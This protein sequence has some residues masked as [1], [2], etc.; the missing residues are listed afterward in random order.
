MAE[1]ICGVTGAQECEGGLSFPRSIQFESLERLTGCPQLKEGRVGR[2][3]SRK[4]GVSAHPT[5]RIRNEF[6]H[7]LGSPFINKMPSTFWRVL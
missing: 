4:P 1:E 2:K 6:H 3:K 5:V 7:I